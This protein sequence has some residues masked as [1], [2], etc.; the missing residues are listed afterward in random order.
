MKDKEDIVCIVRHSYLGE[1]SYLC[2]GGLRSS[3]T[4]RYKWASRDEVIE[5][6]AKVMEFTRSSAMS[7]IGWKLRTHENQ[8]FELYPVYWLSINIE[9]MRADASR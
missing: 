9:K 1:P 4:S 8:Q 2:K 6:L 5:G 3:T 7:F